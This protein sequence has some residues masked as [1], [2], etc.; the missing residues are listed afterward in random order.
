MVI[1]GVSRVSTIEMGLNWL[2]LKY[3]KS[4]VTLFFVLNLIS[5]EMICIIVAQRAAKLLELKV[6]S[7]K[8]MLLDS[9]FL[10]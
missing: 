10:C 3:L 7:P 2:E 9:I 8:K 6:K 1:I 5:N 4:A